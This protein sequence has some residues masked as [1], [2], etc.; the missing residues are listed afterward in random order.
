M[1][2][3]VKQQTGSQSPGKQRWAGDATGLGR[4]ESSFFLAKERFLKNVF[5]STPVRPLHES[6]I[7]AGFFCTP[8]TALKQG[9][10]R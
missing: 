8:P 7:V 1:S 9:G 5:S 4:G 6:T 2:R 10:G 3:D